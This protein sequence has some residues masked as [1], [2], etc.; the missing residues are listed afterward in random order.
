MPAHRVTLN[1]SKALV[2]LDHSFIGRRASMRSGWFSAERANIRVGSRWSLTKHLI[3]LELLNLNDEAK[4][5]EPDDSTDSLS[6]HQDESRNNK[7][8]GSPPQGSDS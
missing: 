4:M 5:P 1:Q 2:R 3:Q 8:D 7:A 6:E